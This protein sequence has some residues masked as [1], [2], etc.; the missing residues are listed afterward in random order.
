MFSL[1]RFLVWHHKW[2]CVLDTLYCFFAWGSLPYIIVLGHSYDC[3]FVLGLLWSVVFQ[4]LPTYWAS[5]TT[6]KLTE[7]FGIVEIDSKLS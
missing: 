2:H 5:V 7:E 1:K 3:L 4:V 6:C